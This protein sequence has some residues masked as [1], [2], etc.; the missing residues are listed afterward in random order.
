ML[1]SVCVLADLFYSNV[2]TEITRTGLSGVGSCLYAKYLRSNRRGT[3]NCENSIWQF[4]SHKSPTVSI[5]SHDTGPVKQGP[6]W[7]S[8]VHVPSYTFT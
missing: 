1:E 5:T 6:P 3:E 8:R 4:M 2:H 7:D